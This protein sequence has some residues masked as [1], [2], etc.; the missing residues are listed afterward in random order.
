MEF[1]QKIK[2]AVDTFVSESKTNFNE[3]KYTAESTLKNVIS[4]AQDELEVQKNNIK[5]TSERV[6]AKLKRSF[7]CR[8][9]TS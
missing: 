5:T 6:Q 3:L 9:S 1:T 7:Y 2:E 4:E 8:K